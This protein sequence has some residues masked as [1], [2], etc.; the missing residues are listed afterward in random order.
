MNEWLKENAWNIIVTAVG[1]TLAYATLNARVLAVEEK[2]GQYPSQDY[3]DLKFQT[4]EQDVADNAELI[5]ELHK[6]LIE[7]DK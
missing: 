3:F 4:I 1:I 7:H 2:V 6:Q 5:E